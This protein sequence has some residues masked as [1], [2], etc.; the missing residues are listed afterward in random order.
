MFAIQIMK[1]PSVKQSRNQNGISQNL[2]PSTS[3]SAGMKC[4]SVLQ[5]QL[6]GCSKC[7]NAISKTL[8]AKSQ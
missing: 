5:R 4:Q 7:Q 6:V 8:Y 3:Q 2:M 1:Y